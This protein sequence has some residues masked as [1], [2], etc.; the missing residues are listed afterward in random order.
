MNTSFSNAFGGPSGG[1]P[2]S[3]AP[4]ILAFKNITVLTTGAPADIA[5]VTLPSWC[6]RYTVVISG[7]RM[8]AESLSGSLNVSAYIV[9]DAAS[10]S[11]N[12]LTTSAA[13]PGSTAVTVSITG[14]PTAIPPATSNT[15]Y[16]H[17]TANSGNAGVISVYLM[18]IPF[19]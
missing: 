4:F 6:T 11:G 3:T 10:G 8:L 12:A 2:T 14:A 1:A 7:S 19:L 9:R 17:Q 13:G 16:L 18:I 5:S 15:L